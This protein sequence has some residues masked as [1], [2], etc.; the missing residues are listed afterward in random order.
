MSNIGGV[1]RAFGRIALRLLCV[2][3]R[4]NERHCKYHAFA[5]GGLVTEDRN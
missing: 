1:A 5:T 4:G 3:P 2:S